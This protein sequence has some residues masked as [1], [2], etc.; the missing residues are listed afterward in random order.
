MVLRRQVVVG[1]VVKVVAPYRPAYRIELAV[2]H[3]VAP[4]LVDPMKGAGE[5]ANAGQIGLIDCRIGHFTLCP[6][7]DWAKHPI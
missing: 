2:D 5:L 4:D 3:L 1:K 7:A 6:Q